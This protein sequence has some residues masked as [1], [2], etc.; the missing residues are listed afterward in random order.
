M[1]GIIINTVKLSGIITMPGVFMPIMI[2]KMFKGMEKSMKTE[3]K[4]K[5]K[6]GK[7]ELNRLANKK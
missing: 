6:F 4:G 2:N 1:I 5:N 7:Q 3:E